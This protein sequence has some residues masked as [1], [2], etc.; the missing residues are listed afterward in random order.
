MWAATGLSLTW[1]D[2]VAHYRVMSTWA[3]TFVAHYRVMSHMGLILSFCPL[4]G[5][6][7]HGADTFNFAHYR[8][9][10]HMWLIL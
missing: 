9:M 4:Q 7:P 10:S 2:F 6:V 1:A 3:D 8:V 5:Y